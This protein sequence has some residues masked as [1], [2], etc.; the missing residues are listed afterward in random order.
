MEISVK[1]ISED[2]LKADVLALPFFEDANQDFYSH[3]DAS[4]GG[5]IKRC[6]DSR[7]F[8]GKE[9]QIILL[10]VNNI[11]SN[12]ILLVGLGKKNE[13]TSEKIRQAGGRAA[14]YIR[15]TGL[16]S[17]GISGR[18]LNSLLPS[19]VGLC[20][21]IYYF[22]EGALLR[23]YRFDKYKKDE[24]MKD[25]KSL[26]LLCSE[27][28]IRLELLDVTV[29]AV[30]FAK[31]AINTP[32][33]DMT[34]SIFG[35]IAESLKSKKITVK[36]LDKGDIEKEGMGA[37]LS[38]S[39]GSDEPPKFIIVEYKGGKGAPIALIGKSITFDSGGISLK[40]AEGMEKMKYDM[41]GGAVVLAAIK[42]A[43][44]LDMP[45]NIVGILPA[46]EN[47]PGGSAS[48]PGDIVKTITG[49]TVEII[50][51]D[52]EGRLTLA[53]AIGY[54]I[55]H[56]KPQ[57][58]IDIAT[59]TGA[60]AIALGDEAIAMMGNDEG[61]ISNMKKA[62]EEIYERVWQMPLYDEYKDYIKGDASDIKNSGGKTGSLVTSAYFLKE[63]VGA[64]PWV[65]LDIAGT[66]WN[67]KDKPYAPKGA[68][69]IGVRLLINFLNEYCHTEIQR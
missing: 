68:S 62:S 23:L 20:K 35:S 12:R 10:H 4:I 51:T 55:R 42:A 18:I 24:E 52:A 29:R 67:D 28:D 43:S 9:K 33:N 37:Y 65:H 22:V 5:L 54:A 11:G 14:S 15:E 66:A 46:A 36:I 49:K 64:T 8:S 31:D 27:N 61:I 38:V 39:K 2:E 41:A 21:P 40:Y 58:I 34:P 44:E 1:N 25:I 26:Y 53:D 50:N 59:L 45:L 60:C 30:N 16:S 47:L 57:S 56:Y 19:F 7:E 69:G 48:K 63:F 3:L 13:I 17:A 32:S 6:L